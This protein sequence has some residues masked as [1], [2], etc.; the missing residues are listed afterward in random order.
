M[1]M[2]LLFPLYLKTLHPITHILCMGLTLR[3]KTSINISLPYG[4]SRISNSI[5]EEATIMVTSIFNITCSQ[6]Q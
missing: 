3:L 1:L 5:R 2:R 6:L 4:C